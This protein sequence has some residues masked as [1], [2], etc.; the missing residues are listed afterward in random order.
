MINILPEKKYCWTTKRVE[1]NVETQ[2]CFCWVCVCVCVCAR[3]RVCV[4]VCVRESECG[5][6]KRER[7]RER[8]SHFSYWLGFWSY[9]AS[10][11]EDWQSF[12]NNDGWTIRSEVAI[13]IQWYNLQQWPNINSFKLINANKTLREKGNKLFFYDFLGF[14]IFFWTKMYFEK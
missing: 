9:V 1:T 12:N 14:K 8:G 2:Y 4:C 6:R 11:V 5:Y 10:T 7:E 3:T 13:K